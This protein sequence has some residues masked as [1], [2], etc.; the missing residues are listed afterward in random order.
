MYENPLRYRYKAADSLLEYRVYNYGSHSVIMACAACP[1]SF[2]EEGIPIPI[3]REYARQA[4][5]K[6]LFLVR[7]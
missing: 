6:R 5:L 7:Q 4:R 2:L 3:N 1:E